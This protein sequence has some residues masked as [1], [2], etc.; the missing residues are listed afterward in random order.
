MNGAIYGLTADSAGR[1][2]AAGSFVN[3]D[4]IPNAS[5][6]AMYDGSW[7]AMQAGAVTDITRSITSDG[8]N[9][10]IGSDALNIAGRTMG[11]SRP[12]R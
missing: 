1:L 12:R 6:V 7:H 5:H 9:V 8:T 4:Q 11:S 3:M 10:Y 2:Y